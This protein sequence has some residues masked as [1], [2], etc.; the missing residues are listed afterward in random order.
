MMQDQG[1]RDIQLPAQ[2]LLR[3]Q[4]IYR[5]L[6]RAERSRGGSLW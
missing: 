3:L 1:E 6:K 2:M 5:S 4:A